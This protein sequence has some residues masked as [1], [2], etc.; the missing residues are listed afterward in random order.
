MPLSSLHIKGTYYQL[1]LWLLMLTLIT[2]LMSV[3]RISSQW[4]C[5]FSFLFIPSFLEGKCLCTAYTWGVGGYV[6]PTCGKDI[7]IIYLDFICMGYLS[8]PYTYLFTQLLTYIIQ[9]DFTYFLVQTALALVIGRP[10]SWFLCSFGTAP[11]FHDFFQ[12]IF[13]LWPFKRPQALCIFPVP[14]PFF[15]R[16]GS[17]LIQL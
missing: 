4:S 15:Q 7:Y 10:F 9:H 1:V 3:W 17:F 12:Y 13:I 5:S 16:A 11:L 14:V 8:P 2:C 6:P